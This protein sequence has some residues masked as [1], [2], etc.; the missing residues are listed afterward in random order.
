MQ[1]VNEDLNWSSGS[2]IN[3]VLKKQMPIYNDQSK[4]KKV[5]DVLLAKKGLTTSDEIIA[6]RRELVL[7]EQGKAIIIQGGDCAEDLQN[8]DKNAIDSTVDVIQKMENIMK[9]RAI[10]IGRM[11]GQYA[12]PRSNDT[13]IKNGIELPSYKGDI[14][15]NIAFTSVAREPN[16]DLM[17]KCYQQAESTMSEINNRTYISHEALL[18]DYEET[19][20]RE[21]KDGI[22]LTSTHLPW[23]GDRTRHIDSAHVEFLRGIINPIGIKIGAT[24]DMEDL[25]KI[26]KVLNPVNEKGKIILTVRMGVGNVE[27]NLPRLIN[28]IQ[29]NKLNVIW[30]SDPMH[31]NG[32]KLNNG[33]K[34]RFLND[35]ENELLEFNAV[36]KKCVAINGGFHLEMTGMDIGECIG[37]SCNEE[38]IGKKYYTLCDPRLNAEQCLNIANVLK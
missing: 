31:G 28:A 18:L 37:L 34:T 38:N 11:A 36:C 10:K 4:L 22:L 6:L 24:T 15:N 33:I 35:I 26:I 30:V 3:A 29:I 2:W 7:V 27:E 1:V 19:L 8:M 9:R 21:T 14:I 17:L 12:K 20:I 25:V 23:I 5:K 32:K 13:E 16:P